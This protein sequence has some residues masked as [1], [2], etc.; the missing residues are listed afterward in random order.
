MLGLGLGLTNFGTKG[1]VVDTPDLSGS[2][3]AALLAAYGGEGLAIDF[4]TDQSIAISDTGTPANNV[5]SSGIVASSGGGLLGP[6]NSLSYL[7]A[8][9]KNIRQGGS[10]QYA[11]SIAPGAHNLYI[12]SASPANQSVTVVS[13]GTYRVTITGS[14]SI[15]VSGAATGTYTAGDND[16]TAATG[17]LTC[18]STTGS[19]TVHIRRTP[20]NSDYIATGANP[21]FALPYEFTSAGA[22]LG[23]RP[24]PSSQNVLLYAMTPSNAAYTK[25][26]VSVSSSSAGGP[27]AGFNI[28]K[29]LE[30]TSTADHRIYR[31]QSYTAGTSYVASCVAKANGRNYFSI[32]HNNAGGILEVI[33]NL[34]NGSVNAV[35]GTGYI[36]SLGDGFYLCEG[37]V[38]AGT[39]S[40]NNL[41]FRLDSTG[42]GTYSYL[43]DGVSGIYIGALVN[44]IG[45]RASSFNQTFG[46][47]ITRAAD[48]ITMATS[49]YPH[50]ASGVCAITG[51]TAP[52]S[53]S[54]QV[55]WQCD[56]GTENNRLRI[57]RDSSTNLRF[58]VT[59]GGV[60]QCNLDL[61][62][63]AGST[64]FVV[65]VGWA[66]N[67]FSAS[68]NAGVPV[69]DT[70]GSIPTVSTMR[71]GSS[72][73][74]EQWGGTIANIVEVP[75]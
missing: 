32:F 51:V 26:A 53:G 68:L 34:S 35:T 23:I 44:E 4:A 59:A 21:L 52:G 5:V 12:N 71:I 2:S 16:F 66:T 62:T 27:F 1:G 37:V 55:L 72:A 6:G 47:S 43:G 17:T 19:G 13:G 36:T 42:A 57:V 31:S 8:T 10:S 54:N 28:E 60:E 3:A 22:C 67:D 25:G 58:I 75:V 9:P 41:Q 39:T 24:E 49:S 20:S 40:A 38:T 18:G 64:E 48:S 56:D 29:M 73:T 14:V 65:S 69:T 74:G 45:K 33:F 11:G 46:T 50:S 30:N 15:T 63:V 70:G 61:G 7:A